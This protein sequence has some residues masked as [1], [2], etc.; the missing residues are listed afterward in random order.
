MSL[1]KCAIRNEFEVHSRNIWFRIPTVK[2]KIPGKAFFKF[3]IPNFCFIQVL[4]FDLS[5]L[6]VAAVWT[7]QVRYH[8]KNVKNIKAVFQNIKALLRPKTRTWMK[9]KF[10][11][12]N[13]KM[14]FPEFSISPS[15]SYWLGWILR[16]T[17]I[18]K[19][20]LSF[21]RKNH[22]NYSQGEFPNFN[23]FALYYIAYII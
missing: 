2:F 7:L 4:V 13:L 9:Q 19:P 5:Y 11:I 6:S 15:G 16:K 23:E 22:K 8:E 12:R 1:L 3:R 21:S 10:G 17:F 20:Q 14:L 18:F